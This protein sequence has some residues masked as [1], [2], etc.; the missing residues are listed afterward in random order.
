[1]LAW[2]IGVAIRATW[3]VHGELALHACMDGGASSRGSV[4]CVALSGTGGAGAMSLGLWGQFTS[5]HG[6]I[7]GSV[8]V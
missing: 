3:R 4:S 2:P 6:I 8:V 1:M 7:K 5:K